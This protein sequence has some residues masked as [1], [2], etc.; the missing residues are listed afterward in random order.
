MD[1]A[2]PCPGTVH[3]PGFL[4]CEGLPSLFK[5]GWA[6]LCAEPPVLESGG[7]PPHSKG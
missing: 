3:G 5:T 6:S 1:T 2:G 4:E 7:K